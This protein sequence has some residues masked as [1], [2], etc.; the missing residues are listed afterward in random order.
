MYDLRLKCADGPAYV[1]NSPLSVATTHWQLCRLGSLLMGPHEM[2][3][4]LP[5]TNEPGNISAA[6]A[7]ALCDCVSWLDRLC[8]DKQLPRFITNPET[9]FSISS[10][11]PHIWTLLWYAKNVFPKF[12]KQK[13]QINVDI[14]FAYLFLLSFS[15]LL[16]LAHAP[17]ETCDKNMFKYKY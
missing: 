2:F 6:K 5:A 10:F 14:C 13:S 4:A 1:V 8:R 9:D 3:C 16:F 7:T 15:M 11:T 17:Q 12:L